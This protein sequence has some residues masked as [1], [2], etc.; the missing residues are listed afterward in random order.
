MFSSEKWGQAKGCKGL[1]V[2]ACL[3][4]LFCVFPSMPLH[5]YSPFPSC[6]GSQQ[7]VEH[8]SLNG[9]MVL[10]MRKSEHMT[11]DSANPEILWNLSAKEA[12]REINCL[13]CNHI[14]ILLFT[15][16]S[17]L[18]LHKTTASTQ[19]EKS[20]VAVRCVS[21]RHSWLLKR[22]KSLVDVWMVIHTWWAHNHYGSGFGWHCS[23]VNV[24]LLLW[25]LQDW[26]AAKHMFASR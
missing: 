17:K 12:F 13:K 7:W 18:N 26:H 24:M 16:T 25:R 3:L 14:Q 9:K 5:F 6:P 4:L 1:T 2:G 15:G 10:C 23:E 19:V 20:C 22:V 11:W 21:H 8:L